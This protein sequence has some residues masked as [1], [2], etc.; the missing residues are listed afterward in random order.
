MFKNYIKSAFK[1]IKKQKGFSF[2]NIIGLG[3]GIASCILIFLWV[4]NQL[5]YDQFHK[6]SDSLYALSFN[7]GGSNMASPVSVYLKKNYPQIINTSRFKNTGRTRVRA[8]DKDM[9]EDGAAFVDPSFLQ[10]FSLDFLKGDPRSA[11]KQPNN[12]VLTRSFAQKYFSTQ[13]PIG[14]TMTIFG[15]DF[16]VTGVIKDYPTNSHL[17]FKFLVSFELFKKFGNPNLK[18]WHFKWHEAYIQLHPEADLNIINKKISGLIQKFTKTESRELLLRPI[19]RLHLYDIDG[20]GKIT[21]IIAFSIIALFVLLIACINFINLS[22]V[23]FSI[24]K[25]EVGLRKTIGAQ[26]RQLVVQ[27]FIETFIVILLAWIVGMMLIKLLIPEFNMLIGESIP[28]N[29]IFKGSIISGIIGLL[30]LSGLI[31]GSYPALYISSFRPVDIFRGDKQSGNKGITLRKGLVI[32]Q[33]ILSIILIFGTLVLSTQLSH[34]QNAPLGYDKHQVVTIQ[35]G[36]RIKS[37]SSFKNSLLGYKDIVN[38]TGTMIPPFRLNMMAGDGQVHWAGQE[39]TKTPMVLITVDPDYAK[40]FGLKIVN[41]R[42]FSSDRKTDLKNAWVVNETAVKTMGMDSPIGK[43]LEVLGNKKVIIGVVKDYNIESLQEKIRPMAMK[44][45]LNNQWICIKI[46]NNN[47]P[48]TLKYIKTQWGIHSNN[49]PFE[50]NF[51]D[52]Q[53]SNLYITEKRMGTMFKYFGILAIILSCL[54]M[55]G[56]ASFLS[57]SRT[58]EIGVR[59]IL[60]SKITGLIILLSKDFMKWVCYAMIIAWPIAWF[61]MNKSLQ[62]YAYRIKIGWEFFVISGGLALIIAVFSIGYQVIKTARINPID[63]LRYK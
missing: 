24:R 21:I 43:W 13:D 41:G 38:V 10:M 16:K 63:S 12:I 50:Y 23:Q 9:M 19:T 6:N 20:G 52:E 5:S 58:K 2:I 40:S 11:L 35:T 22:T 17:K 25:K 47:I 26:K 28:F 14:K 49:F 7:D 62:I 15:E 54:G 55:F 61:L 37:H 18:K 29:S 42:F 51:L 30:L 56:L 39:H 27:F 34:M 46:K 3:V 53:I 4:N 31:A 44:L 33:F 32:F 45:S 48:A 36:N 60:G 1:N 59:K 57:R 8:N